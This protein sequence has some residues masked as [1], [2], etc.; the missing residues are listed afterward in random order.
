[1]LETEFESICIAAQCSFDDVEKLVDPNYSK[2]EYCQ[3]CGKE[4][5]LNEM[6]L[7][8][9]EFLC[10]KHSSSLGNTFFR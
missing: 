4:Y 5:G 2:L 10:I 1:M 3:P 7:V 6:Y 9:G 8:D